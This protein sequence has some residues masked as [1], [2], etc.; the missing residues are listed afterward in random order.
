[1]YQEVLPNCSWTTP[2]LNVS[3]IAYMMKVGKLEGDFVRRGSV[4]K[5]WVATTCTVFVSTG[6]HFC[7]HP[8]TVLIQ[9]W[10]RFGYNCI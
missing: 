9:I 10:T 8:K 6:S 4:P 5:M 1:V 3:L 7:H 2:T